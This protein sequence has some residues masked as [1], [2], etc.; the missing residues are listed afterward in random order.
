[1]KIKQKPTET[2]LE[3]LLV[4]WERG[5]STVREVHFALRD[6][7]HVRLTTILKLMQIMHDKGL[8]NRDESQ[9]TH[10][11]RAVRSRETTQRAFVRDLVE[12]LF[13]GSSTQLVMQ[14]LSATKAT[15]QELLEV[16]RLFQE[17][18]GESE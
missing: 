2:E 18:T 11:Y 13:G 7:K 15:P 17:K 6:K 3:I 5:P 8:V 1:M 12:R 14:A 16:R 4:L 10:V 9:R